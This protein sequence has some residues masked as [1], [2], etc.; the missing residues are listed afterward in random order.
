MGL[1]EQA[2]WNTQQLDCIAGQSAIRGKGICIWN[3]SIFPQIKTVLRLPALEL[4]S[5]WTQDWGHFIPAGWSVF[6]GLQ[7]SQQPALCQAVPISFPIVS[8]NM[9]KTAF[10]SSHSLPASPA[11]FWPP[12]ISASRSAILP[13][14]LHEELVEQKTQEINVPA[15]RL[16]TALDG[17]RVG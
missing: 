2:S 3:R 1:Q 17:I 5:P 15:S 10:R 12:L 7:N 9:S 16:H 11:V 8:V 6:Q 14:A 13:A 4:L